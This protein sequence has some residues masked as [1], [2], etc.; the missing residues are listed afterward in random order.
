MVLLCVAADFA[1]AMAL[2]EAE[3]RE[4]DRVTQYI[5]EHRG[6]KG[7]CSAKR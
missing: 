6:E 4:L 3:R 7:E 5:R 1:L 2:Q